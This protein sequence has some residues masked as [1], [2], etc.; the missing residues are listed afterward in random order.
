MDPLTHAISGAALARALPKER[1][2]RRQAVF[3]ILLTMAPDADIVLRL[4]SDTLYLQHHRGLTHSLLMLPLW[5]WLIFSL[6]TPQIKAQP[7]MPWLIGLALVLHI[8]LDLI[9]TFGTMILAPV[10]DWR[11]SLDLLFIVDPIFTGCMLLPLLAGFVWTR[12]KR[13][14]GALSLL[15]MLAYLGLAWHNQQQAIELARKEHPEARAHY[16]LPLAFSPFIW[17]LI[18]EYPDRYARAAVD[19]KP[20]F[21]GTRPLFDEGFIQQIVSSSLNSPDHIRWQSF[22]AMRSIA[23][24]DQRPGAAFYHWF[25]RFPVLLSQDEEHIEIGDLAFG[26]GAPGVK[27]GFLLRIDHEACGDRSWLIWRDGRASPLTG[28]RIPFDW[29]DGEAAAASS[30]APCP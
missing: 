15:L 7:L 3:L 28:T 20:G 30:V 6:S 18:A 13:K 19:L 9:T 26:A 23:D 17:Q 21:A 22:P 4:F 8:G 1:L 2:P 11:A 10:S 25:A 27:A 29:L 24:I 12:H 16:A 5:T 14:L